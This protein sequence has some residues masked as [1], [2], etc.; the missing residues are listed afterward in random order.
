MKLTKNEWK[1]VRHLSDTFDEF[2]TIED[3]TGYS[4]GEMYKVVDPEGFSKKMEEWFAN[5]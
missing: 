3:Y 2:T 1:F 4:I 5:E